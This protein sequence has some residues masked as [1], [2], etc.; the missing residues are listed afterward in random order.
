MGIQLILGILIGLA[1]ISSTPSDSFIRIPAIQLSPRILSLIVLVSRLNINWADSR[2]PVIL[3]VVYNALAFLGLSVQ[4]RKC[5]DVAPFV[6]L[7][8]EGRRVYL[9]SWWVWAIREVV[10]AL[11]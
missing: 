2:M 8:V 4:I 10:V 9:V 6:G 5:E 1:A 7:D 11:V 3:S